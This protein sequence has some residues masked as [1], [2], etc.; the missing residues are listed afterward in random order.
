M[1]DSFIRFWQKTKVDFRSAR[2]LLIVFVFMELFS[3]TY[4]CYILYLL[5]GEPAIAEGTLTNVYRAYRS[6][7]A[8]YLISL[9]D[10]EY[11]IRK[12]TF[13]E[14]TYGI[15]SDIDIVRYGEDLKNQIGKKAYVEYIKLGHNSRV[16]MRLTIDGKNYIDGEIA[17]IDHIAEH[18]N[19]LRTAIV[20]LIMTIILLLFVLG[21]MK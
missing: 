8:G 9:P 6:G 21:L 2:L 13:S 7:M 20:L 19:I 5:S 18:M 4:T 17:R 11:E 3:I 12:R 1:R 10:S 14:R 16:V 15:R